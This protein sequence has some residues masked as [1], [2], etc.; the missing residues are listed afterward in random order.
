MTNGDGND[1]H[2]EDIRAE[3]KLIIYIMLCPVRSSGVQQATE[4][5]DWLVFVL[6]AKPKRSSYMVRK[7]SG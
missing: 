5:L 2:K 3:G 6:S 4:R 7:C 1:I